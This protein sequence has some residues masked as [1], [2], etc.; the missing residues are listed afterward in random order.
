MI[1]AKDESQGLLKAS[2]ATINYPAGGE[3]YVFTLEG[4]AANNWR[5]HLLND[6]FSWANKSNWTRF[7][8][9]TNLEKIGYACKLDQTFQ[10]L[11]YHD[12][13]TGKVLVHYEGDGSKIKRKPHEN[14]KD[15]KKPF[16]ATSSLVGEVIIRPGI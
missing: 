10:R 1:A 14:S 2:R 4:L 16:S 12:K 15:S 9:A 3:V 6:T 13:S 11:V 7:D 5:R 8:A